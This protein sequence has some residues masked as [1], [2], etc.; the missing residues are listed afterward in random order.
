MNTQQIMEIALK[1]AGFDEIPQDSAIYHPGENIKKVFIGIDIDSAEL[2]V[3]KDLGVD[4]VI[5]HHPRGGKAILNYPRVLRRHIEQM[6]AAGVPQDVAEKA[7]ADKVFQSEATAHMSNYDHYPSL[8]EL[9]DMPFMNIHLPLDEI[10]RG[11]MVKAL[12]KLHKNDTI[13]D[14]IE[15]FKKEMP[16]FRKAATEIDVR[17]GNLENKIGRAVV[18]HAAATNGGYPVAKAYF[19]YGV[20]TLIYIH[21]NGPDSKKLKEEFENTGK[22]LV[23]TGHIVSDSLGI[24]PFIAKLK[25]RGLETITCG[26]IVV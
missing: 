5:S 21:C 1:L 19:E 23:V 13:E 16:E 10:G 25:R 14:L 26:V 4:L 17:V 7:I 22:S 6:K 9:L 18:S 15:T 20:D 11:R 24:N 3:A 12:E 2:V 8:A